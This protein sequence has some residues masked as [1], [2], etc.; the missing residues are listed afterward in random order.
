MKIMQ[1]ITLSELGGAQSVVINIANYLCRD[2]TIIVVAGEGD[3]KLWDMLDN[4]II[5]IRCKSLR[6]K[7]SFLYDIITWFHF[8]LLYLKYKPDIIH[9]HSSKAG[10]IGR[11][12][13]PRKKTIYTVHGFDSIRF[14]NRKFLFC[15]RILQH[16]C[17]AIVGVSL[18]DKNALNDE[19]ITTNVYNIYNGIKKSDDYVDMPVDVSSKYSKKVICIARIAKQKRFDLFIE[20]AKKLPEYAFIWIGNQCEVNDVPKNVFMLGNIVGAGRYCR[21]ADVFMLPSNYEGLPIVIIEAMSYGK[22]IVASHV[23]GIGE[24]VRDGINGF[25]VENDSNIIANKIRII[26]EDESL[27][28]KLGENSLKIYNEELTVEKMVNKYMCIYKRIIASDKS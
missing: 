15:E 1:V 21:Y 28:N 26:L 12:A 11:L 5:K 3:G 19:G 27:A 13:F 10:A 24:I 8:I 6:R 20:T 17:S 9:L 14:A 18:Y 2:N 23:G 4:R 22:P 25:T 16:F 7:L